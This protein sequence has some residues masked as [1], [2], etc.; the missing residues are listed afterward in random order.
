[1]KRLTPKL[2]AIV[3]LLLSAGC[4]VI[5]APNGGPRDLAPPHAAEYSPDSAA[6]NFTGQ[7]ISIRFDE[8]IQLSDLR[9]QLIVSPPLKED[10]DVQVRQKDLVIKLSDTLRPNTTYTINFG[11]AIKDITEGNVLGG[12]RYVFSTGPV[13]DSLQLGGKVVNAFSNGG[14]KGVLVLLYDTN[15]DSDLYKKRPVYFA[16]TGDGGSFR[17]TNLH[18]GTYQLAA[19]ADANS[20]YIYDNAEERVAFLGEPVVLEKSVDTLRLRLFREERTKAG[21]KK[22]SLA[23]RG[24]VM[25]EM[26]APLKSPSLEPLEPLPSSVK[27]RTEYGVKKDTLQFWF[28]NY[29]SDTLRLVVR[30]GGIPVDTAIVRIP[31]PGGNK[32]KGGGAVDETEKL[33]LTSNLIA[34]QPFDLRKSI[35]L[36][37]SAA[38]MN[39]DKAKVQLLSGGKP[40]PYKL[41]SDTTGFRRILFHAKLEEDSSYLFFIPPG[42]VTDFFGNKNDSLYIPF[43]MRPYTDY[44]SIRLLLKNV[45]AG[46]HYLLQLLD[47]KGELLRESVCESDL[48]MTYDLLLPGAYNIR[49]I[50][51]ENRNGKWD[52]GD[53]LAKKQPEKVIYY[54]APLKVRAGWDMDAEWLMK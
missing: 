25:L 5:V 13:I 19:L 1:M 21:I 4:A 14:E 37:S 6:V 27:Y 17:I 10:P 54:S 52:T 41:E 39:I 26:S 38:I 11:N 24:R 2:A 42:A 45:P 9:N 33:T 18:P 53:Y 8:Y 16:K 29:D 34:N 50:E 23:S 15:N 51:D 40:V 49:L 32:G 22:S 31:K 20:N 46:K 28:R 30:D 36:Y 44:G 43:P 12:F 3:V 35:A 48:T 7:K 47:G